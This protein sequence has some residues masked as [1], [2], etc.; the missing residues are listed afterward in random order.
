[1]GEYIVQ[2]LDDDE[3]QL[4]WLKRKGQ[5]R[6]QYPNGDLFVGTLNGARKKEGQGR[7]EWA[8]ETAEDESTSDTRRPA[9][10]T[11]TY[12]NGLRSGSGRMLYRDGSEY[13]GQWKNGKA[14]GHGTMRYANKDVYSGLWANG[15]RSGHGAYSFP[16]SG[17]QLVGVWQGNSI[18]RGKWVLGGAAAY[19]GEFAQDKPKGR[20]VF[21]HAN[22]LA[23]EGSFESKGDDDEEEVNLTFR[24]DV[25]SDAL[26]RLEDVTVPVRD[27]SE[28]ENQYSIK[29]PSASHSKNSDGTGSGSG[30]ASANS[31]E[32]A[33]SAEDAIEVSPEVALLRTIFKDIDDNS[34]DGKVDLQKMSKFL[35][36]DATSEYADFLAKVPAAGYDETLEVL[37]DFVQGGEGRL[38]ADELMVSW[39]L[40]VYI[41]ILRPCLSLWSAYSRAGHVLHVW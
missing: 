16:A 2:Y 1:M 3:E 20:G 4:S 29:R 23:Q 17:A 11:G 19:Y 21:I 25:I 38:T 14:D 12:E 9:L 37:S 39:A 27:A 5:V 36:S 10:Y 32:D 8:Q 30:D 33:I 18:T 26:S 24:R 34:A 7:Y 6:I 40:C 13:Q 31:E 15:A 28:Q 35:V 22:G 41:Y